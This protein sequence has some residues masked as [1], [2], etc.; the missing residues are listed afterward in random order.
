MNSR[1]TSIYRRSLICFHVFALLLFLASPPFLLRAQPAAPFAPTEVSGLAYT[2]AF[3]PDADPDPAIPTPE[4]LLNFPLGSRAA[5]SAEIERCLRQWT[6]A[7]PLRTRLVEYA[8]SHEGRSLFYFVLTSPRNHARLNEIQSDLGRLGDPRNLSEAETTRL[9]DSLPAVAWLG[10][11]IHGDE[12]EGSDAALAVIHHLLAD[13]RPETA[14]LLEDIVVILDPLQNPDGRDRYLKMIAEHRGTT[15]NVDQQSLL[16]SGYWPRGRMNH[17]LFDL[18]RD[19]IFATQP[20]TRGRLREVARWN[21]Q[22]FVDVHGMSGEDTYLFSP[23]REPLNPHQPANRSEWGR[24]FARDQAKA[25]DALGW[26]YYTGEWNENWYPGYSDAWSVFRGAVGIL[27]EV[28]S[29]GQ[30]GVRHADGRI[31]SQRE[32][33]HQHVVSTLAN[34]KTFQTHARTRLREFAAERRTNIGTNSPHAHTTWAILPSPNRTRLNSFLDSLQAQ[35]LELHRLTNALAVSTARD[36]LGRTW[37]NRTLPA[38]TLLVSGRQ[39]TSPLAATL[40]EFDPRMSAKAVEDERRELL[41]I[42]QSRIYDITGWNVALFHGLETLSLP[43]ALPADAQPYTRTS[44]IPSAAASP[45]RAPED[46]VPNPVAWILDG[47]DDAS[48]AAAGRLMER[49][50]IVRVAEKPCRLDERDYARGSVVVT[51]LDNRRH[52]DLAALLRQTA[53]E[54]PAAP[55]AIRGGLGEDDWPDLGG[56]YFRR[57]Q[58]PRIA[59]VGRGRVNPYDFGSIWFL[60]D[61]QLGLRHSHL[62]DEE[63]PPEFARYN[64]IVLPDRGGELPPAWREPLKEWVK[65]GGTLIAIESAAGDLAARTNELTRVR[66]LQDVLGKLPDYEQMIFREWLARSGPIPALGDVWTNTVPSGFKPPWPEAGETVKEDELKKRDTWNRLFMPQGAL[67]AART[68][69]RHWLTFG[70]DD[71]LPVLAGRQPVLMSG[72]GIETPVRFGV[73]TESALKPAS[74]PGNTNTNANA[75][76]KASPSLDPDKGKADSKRPEVARAGWSAT[77][78]GMELRLRMSGLLW[79]E[80]AQRLAN[81]AVVTREGLGRGQVILFA[82]S[83]CFRGAARGTARLLANALVYGPGFGTAPNIR[84]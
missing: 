8:R 21:P 49:G 40:F 25:F 81:S 32:S 79:P 42:G 23:P 45:A 19:W 6:N 17:Y 24:I 1:P 55:V 35:G 82:G 59:L 60:L 52:P 11:C 76:A 66:N 70:T 46:D 80:A 47:A 58:P 34:L 16:H 41:R 43:Q 71:L 27:Y 33:I 50:L 64:V 3:F 15:P 84:P 83:P 63:A 68:D 38:G 44:A 75:N 37:T 61:Q 74:S 54:V 20:E 53:N 13:R 56:E 12:T 7:V 65:A 18:N 14:R 31:Q 9:V 48:V 67:L 77:P 73:F 10:Y 29:I 30:D 78:E 22:L 51:R 39:P 2:N 62:T 5:T 26:I 69:P 72:A 28:A 4:S 36:A 57:L